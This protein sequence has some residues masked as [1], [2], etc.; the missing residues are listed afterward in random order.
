MLMFRFS[1]LVSTTLE[2]K[3]LR[4]TSRRFR[5]LADEGVAYAHRDLP[6]HIKQIQHHVLDL[7]EAGSESVRVIHA[8]CSL[9]ER[10]VEVY[11]QAATRL[12]STFSTLQPYGSVLGTVADEIS[13][14]GVMLLCKGEYSFV[15]LPRRIALTKSLAPSDEMNNLIRL[16]QAL[17]RQE[18]ELEDVSTSV[19]PLAFVISTLR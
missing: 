14:S 10:H 15:Y 12:E 13:G 6:V 7:C 3:R 5:K 4:V 19:P 18:Q 11:R 17:S 9:R 16:S 1:S 2:A 8:I